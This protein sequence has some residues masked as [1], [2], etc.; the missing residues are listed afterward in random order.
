[1]NTVAERARGRTGSSERVAWMVDR[2]LAAEVLEVVREHCWLLRFLPVGTE[3]PLWSHARGAGANVREA[4]VYAFEE[5]FDR[6]PG[7]LAG[8]P[9]DQRNCTTG[10]AG[11]VLDSLL[12]E[13]RRSVR[14]AGRIVVRS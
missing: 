6:T 9:G 1:M 8:I 5:W 4:M 14:R 11:R 7:R 2:L 12:K 10:E 3:V 13:A